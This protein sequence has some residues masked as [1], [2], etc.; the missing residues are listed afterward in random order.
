VDRTTTLK[1]EKGFFRLVYNDGA[2]FEG[3]NENGYRGGW[4]R[5]IDSDGEHSSKDY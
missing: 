4:G 1:K 3:I 5:Y 2:I